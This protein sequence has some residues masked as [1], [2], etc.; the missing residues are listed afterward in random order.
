MNIKYL[1]EKHQKGQRVECI[2]MQ[3]AQN[4]STGMRGTIQF[5]DDMATI[6]VA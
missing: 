6:H 2:D 5:V 1:K 4:V 3:D